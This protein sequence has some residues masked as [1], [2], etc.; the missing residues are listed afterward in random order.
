MART[1]S[2]IG[3]TISHYRIFERLGGG[4]MGVVYRAEDVKLDRFVALKFLPHDVAKDPQVLARF[5]REAKAASALN[6]ANI[7]TIHE[8]D[9]VNGL[10]FIVMEFLDGT[11]LKHRIE[12]GPLQLEQVLDWSIEIAEAL[13]AAHAEGIVHRDIKPTNIFITK[14]GR[15]KILDFGLAKLTPGG[16]GISASAMPT[17]ATEE[18]LTSPGATLGTLAYMSP[19]QARGE[20][21]DARTDL[22]SFGAVLYEMATG[23]MAFPGN[24]PAVIHD[25][26]L[27]REPAPLPQVNPDSPAKLDRIIRHALEKATEK[28]FAS[29]AQMRAELQSLRQERL[30]EFGA[31]V[32]ITKVVRK[33]SFIVGALLVLIIVGVSA[34]LLYRHY[35]RARWV[36][37]VAVAELQNLA[38]NKQGVAFYKLVKQAEQ[39]S[40]DDPALKQV[41]TRNL[42]PYPIL[43]TPPGADVFFREYGNP[44]ASWEYLGKTPLENAKFLWAQYALKF[45]KDGYEQVEVTNEYI[46]DSGTQSII[47][48]P[49]G[50]LPRNMIHI[51]S[52]VV[53]VLGLPSTQVDEFLIDKYEVT[54]FDFKKFVDAGGYREPKYWKLPFT[55]DGHALTFEQAMALFVDKTDRPAPSTWELGNY[56]AGQE[57]Y[58]VSG[59][60]WY[61]AAAYAEFV[62]KNLPTVYHWHQ[63]ASLGSLSDILETSNFS[64]KGP[65][66][67]GSYAGLG[68]YGTYDMAGNVKEWCFNSDGSRR[69]ILGGDSTEP[70]YMYQLPDAKPPFDRSTGNGFRLI[71]YLKPVPLP[72]ALI[73]QVNFQGIDYRNAKPLPD[74]VLRIYQGLYSYDRTPLDAKIESV[75]DNSPYWRRERISFN[76]AYNSER[77]T[78]FLYLP[79]NV[80]P[81]YQAVLHFPGVEARNFH[82]FTD[83]NLFSLDF[84]MKGGRAV[85]CPVYKGTYERITHPVTPGSSEERD[86]TIQRSK[87]LRRSLDYLETRP[88]IDHE[89]LAFYGFSWGSQEGPISLALE[90]RFKTAVLADGG[91]NSNKTLPEV[92]PINF[93]PSIRIPVLMIN[94]RYDFGIPFETCQQP[95]FRLLG[96]PAADKRQVVL[97]SGHGLPYTP[98]FRETLDWLDHYLGRVN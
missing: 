34:G 41:E 36:H 16:A 91:C 48:D 15:A 37:E 51:P 1:D 9:E 47:L 74:S 30:I 8:I 75:D 66:S 27:N 23:R 13:E 65:A 80:S 95:F 83:L 60:S 12:A 50:S 25:A 96:T 57:K 64:G 31:S 26:I 43:T 3:T 61:E 88:D 42:W 29:A 19:E 92:D 44:Q 81:P 69:Y 71:K 33:P 10:A 28:R 86:E 6:H 87:D 45:V 21:L 49:I 46:P 98:W 5:Q 18:M 40:P 38:L 84:L 53:S 24:A 59:V 2:L 22:F 77:I 67:V 20:E 35:A 76:A 90:N 55:K 89:R 58:P 39:Y 52:G 82:T 32:P 4:G 62:G 14:R 72:D 56:P 97:E 73:A 54:N 68:P 94:G 11:T 70:K 7:C 93:V 17:A 78:A 79:K 85:I 63:A